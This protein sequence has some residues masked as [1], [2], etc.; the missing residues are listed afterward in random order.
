MI[1]KWKQDDL[2]QISALLSQ[3][4]ESIG[5]SFPYGPKQIA[6][7][8]AAMRDSDFYES[9]VYLRAEK[10]VGFISVVYYRTVLH[11]AGTAL[12]NELVVDKAYRGIGIG[13]ELL[14]YAIKRAQQRRMDE[15]E[16]GV[17]KQNTAAQKFYRNNGVNEEYLLLGK[18]L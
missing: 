1:R 4:A 10:V 11:R 17:V 18:E 5:E 9:F 8:Y 3:L 2:G 16:V 15:I 12:I 13:K 14:S 6:K 7:Q